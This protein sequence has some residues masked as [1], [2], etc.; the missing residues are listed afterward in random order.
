MFSELNRND[1]NA[2]PPELINTEYY[3]NS[4]AVTESCEL[5]LNNADDSGDTIDG[6]ETLLNHTDKSRDATDIRNKLVSHTDQSPETC[7]PCDNHLMHTDRSDMTEA[8]Y[9]N[10]AQ[11]ITMESSVDTPFLC[12]GDR[13]SNNSNKSAE[14]NESHQELR[15]AACSNS[16]SSSGCE[17]TDATNQPPADN[18]SRECYEDEDLIASRIDLHRNSCN[19]SRTAEHRHNKR[20]ESF[21]QKLRRTFTIKDV[22]TSEVTRRVLAIVIKYALFIFNFVAW[23]RLSLIHVYYFMT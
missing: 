2:L 13:D 20:K 9:N 8:T 16:V 5:L 4:Q 14:T 15:G 6:V 22:H 11:S 23:V 7:E 3:H 1:T 12:T 18:I 21:E 19:T 17:E 10:D